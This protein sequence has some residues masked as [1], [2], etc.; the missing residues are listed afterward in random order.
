MEESGS[1]RRTLR[2]QRLR[3]LERESANLERA[4]ELFG[5]I[6]DS[7]AR[8]GHAGGVL[9]EAERAVALAEE[10]RRLGILDARRVGAT[11]EDL[12]RASGLGSEDLETMLSGAA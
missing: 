10:A 11:M 2:A 6:R 3:L 12:S 4:R 7:V 9:R 1:V 5:Q 8:G